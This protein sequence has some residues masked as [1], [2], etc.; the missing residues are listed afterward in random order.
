MPS[1]VVSRVQTY[2]ETG[3]TSVPRVMV[4][5]L[6]Y[7]QFQPT[8]SALIL[9]FNFS[10]TSVNRTAFTYSLS[11]YQV[12]T[13]LLHYNYLAVQAETATFYL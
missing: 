10:I 6:G 8:S 9:G 2:N 12:V 5:M 13:F 7:G 4:S 11:C 1:G 3:F